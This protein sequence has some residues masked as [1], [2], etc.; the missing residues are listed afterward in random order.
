M[1]EPK[2]FLKWDGKYFIS[3][4]YS[5]LSEIFKD[6]IIIE[7]ERTDR[8]RFLTE[9]VYA[10]IYKDCGPLAAIHSAFLN[11]G[12]GDLFVASCDV[13]LIT[14]GLV[15]R[16]LNA[17][18]S[19]DAV[20]PRTSDGIHPLCAMYSSKC[21]PKIDEYLKSGGRSING[22]LKQIDVFHIEVGQDEAKD[23]LN[24][25][26]PEEYQTMLGRR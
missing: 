3:R 12:K 11:S 2:P 9:R 20:V 19:C 26:T 6:V 17:G 18:A 24:V 7:A 10:D 8:Y 21:L 15:N 13:P 1:G 25:N 23:L 4:I 16:V 22:F 5:T 14:A